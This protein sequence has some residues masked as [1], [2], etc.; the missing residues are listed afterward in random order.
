MSIYKRDKEDIVIPA[1]NHILLT[2]VPGTG[3]TTMGNYLKDNH[4]FTHYNLEDEETLN[5]FLLDTCKF[6]SKALA[7]EKTVISW[8]F[9]PDK[10][11][12]HV[13]EMKRS[14]FTLIWLDDGGD[15]TS[16]LR[17][18]TNRNTVSK[19]AYDIQ[20]FKIKDSGAID[21]IQPIIINPFKE[22]GE[23]KSCVDIAKELSYS[24]TE[25]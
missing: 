16:S 11:T 6:I 14:G 9:M 15:R 7:N 22:N 4:E 5:N 17:T 18:F 2:G 3:K 24:Q 8:G 10:H 23:F 12:N 25:T 19:D 21:I 13:L 1:N 20:M